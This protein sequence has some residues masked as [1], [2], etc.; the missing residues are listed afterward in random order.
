MAAPEVTPPNSIPWPPIL[1]GSAILAGVILHFVWPLPW[2]GG[3]AGEFMFMGGLIMI[4]AALFIDVRVYLELRKHATTIL[5]HRSSSH[6]VISGPFGFSRNPIYLSNT[7]LT[8]GI[9]MV[10]GIAWMFATGILAA[11]A[12]NELAIKREEKHLERKFGS[13]WRHYRKK[14]RRWI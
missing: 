5:P 12:V 11:L 9:G 1:Y 6:L 8:F 2:P 3:F 10:F 13:H 4:A 14:V 7:V